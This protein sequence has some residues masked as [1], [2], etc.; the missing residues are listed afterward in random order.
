MLISREYH[1]PSWWVRPPTNK[2]GG[3]VLM[4]EAK[5]PPRAPAWNAEVMLLEMLFA[6][7]PDT[8]KS[9]LKLARAIVVPMNAE[10]YPK[11]FIF[12]KG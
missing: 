3:Y 8:P 2:G 9:A 10:S 4:N 11:L 1:A 7:G 5:A 6:C 12:D